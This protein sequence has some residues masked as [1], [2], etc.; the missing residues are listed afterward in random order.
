MTPKVHVS[1]ELLGS[2]PCRVVLIRGVHLY[3]GY[4]EVEMQSSEKIHWSDQHVLVESRTEL[5]Y[6]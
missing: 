6:L 4:W 1:H 5:L 2:L 3:L